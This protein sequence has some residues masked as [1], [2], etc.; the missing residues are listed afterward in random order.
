[1]S[2]IDTLITDR[3]SA[4]LAFM[5]RLS[6]TVWDDM[7]EDERRYCLAGEQEPLNASDYPLICTDGPLFAGTGETRGAYNASDLN[8]VGLAVKYLHDELLESGYLIP[9]Y[10]EPKTDWY[11]ED[12]TH[13][14]VENLPTEQRMA[15]YLGNIVGIKTA[16]SAAQEIPDS[17]AYLDID[18]ANNIEKLLV[19]TEDR[20]DRMRRGMMLYSGM[21]WSGQ[22]YSEFTPT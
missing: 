20:I 10:T 15:A 19:E 1:M 21:A 7:T 18:G 13:R 4:D 16:I 2:V 5:R 17:M 12:D 9:G 3:T 11:E 14:D 6:E 8:R 22:I